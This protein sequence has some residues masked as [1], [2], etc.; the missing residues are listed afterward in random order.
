MTVQIEVQADPAFLKWK[1]PVLHAASTVIHQLDI[2]RGMI[3]I[4]LTHS[5]ELRRMNRDYAGEDH[6]T[7]VLSFPSGEIDPA[8]GIQYLGDIMIAVPIAQKQ[9]E[10]KGHQLVEELS[11][12]AIHGT[13]HLLG[14]DHAE[15]E[16]R[17][18]MWT[19]QAKALESLG[20]QDIFEDGG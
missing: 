13:L 16:D 12:L 2:A 20:I 15:P 5:D 8:N 19:Q 10:E 1:M 11:L 14:Y 7:D 9:A 17:I 4:V 3:T 18:R 6:A